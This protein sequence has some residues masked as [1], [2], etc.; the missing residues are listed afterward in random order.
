MPSK[1]MSLLAQARN[2]KLLQQHLARHQSVS[3]DTIYH[4][5]AMMDNFNDLL[6]GLETT[7]LAQAQRKFPMLV[8]PCTDRLDYPTFVLDVVNWAVDRQ[9]VHP[10]IDLI[11]I[12]AGYLQPSTDALI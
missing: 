11:V 1:H 4:L 12:G 6:D 8:D 3:P 9:V 2:S 7:V 10:S 5:K